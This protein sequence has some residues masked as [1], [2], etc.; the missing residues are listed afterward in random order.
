MWLVAS[1][2]CREVLAG[3]AKADP[4]ADDGDGWFF[5]LG[6]QQRRQE[7]VSGAEDGGWP[8]GTTM[9][10][11]HLE[12][13]RRKGQRTYCLRPPSTSSP[14]EPANNHTC[15]P[16]KS[17]GGEWSNHCEWSSHLRHHEDGGLIIM[18]ILMML[19]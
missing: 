16:D 11:G 13:E 9:V 2:T 10:L 18:I 5:G 14:T 17:R 1:R 6:G 15:T 4:A 3:P 12:E 7:A 19:M 8:A